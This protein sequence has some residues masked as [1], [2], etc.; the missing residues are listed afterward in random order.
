MV[1]HS[2]DIGG[3]RE[4]R[5]AL[6]RREMHA[7]AVLRSPLRPQFTLLIWLTR[8]LVGS[9]GSLVL[10]SVIAATLLGLYLAKGPIALAGL[11]PRITQ[12]LNEKVAPD[13][14]FKLGGLSVTTHGLGP[15]LAI[16]NLILENR[17]G[18]TILSAPHAEISVDLISLIYGKVVPTR[19]EI[20]G[21]EV[22]L[23]LRPDGS[24]AVSAGN[25]KQQ[26]LLVSSLTAAM[27]TPGASAPVAPELPPL[28]GAARPRSLA[29]KRIAAAL[30]LLID[31]ATRP[32]GPLAK[33]D[34]V[35]ISQGRFVIEDELNNETKLYEGLQLSLAKTGG[36][37]NLDLSAQG[38]NGPWSVSARAAGKPGAARRLDFNFKNISIDEISLVSGARNI[39][40]DFDMPVSS[41]LTVA[42]DPKNQLTDA[43]GSLHFDPGYLRFDDPNDEPRL[44]DSIDTA[45]HWDGAARQMVVDN[46]QVRTGGTDLTL[47]G[48]ITPPVREGDDWL[49]GLTNS[50]RGVYGA[51][52]PGEDQIFFDH[53]DFQ[54]RLALDNKTFHIDRLAFSGPNNG[55]AMAG[56]VDWKNGPHMSMGASLSPTPA[57]IVM[58]LWPAFMA[59]D[60]RMWFLEHVKGGIITHGT[61]RMNFD[62]AMIDHMHHQYP[63]PNPALAIDFAVSNGSLTFLK[64]VPPLDGV[65][66]SGH[67]TGRTSTFT[68]TS[69]HMQVGSV[70]VL[71]LSEGG[72]H[73]DHAEIRPTPAEFSARVTGDIRAV[74]ALLNLDALKP[75]VSL[76][77]DTTQISGQIDGQLGILLRL[78]PGADPKRDFKLS[79]DST[80][81]QFSAQKLL[82]NQDLTDATLRVS[83]NNDGLHAWGKGHCL[84]GLADIDVTRPVG[85][86]YGKAVVSMEMDDAARAKQGLAVLPGLSGPIGMRITAPLGAPGPV[87][88]QIDLDLAR[89]EIDGLGIVK[90][91]GRPGKASFELSANDDHTTTLDQLVVD[92]GGASIKGSVKIGTPDDPSQFSAHLTQVKLSPGDDARVDLSKAADTVKVVIHAVSFDG[93]PFLKTLTLTHAEDKG[94]DEAPSHAAK[95]KQAARLLAKTTTDLNIDVA[96]KAESLVG[97]NKVAMSNVDL[98]LVKNSDTLKQFALTAR[99]GRQSTIVGHLDHADSPAPQLDLTTDN[100]GGLLAFIDLYKHM[101]GG[102]LN[103]E[104][105]LGHD[106]MAGSLIVKNFVLA[107]EPALRRLVSEGVPRNTR[108]GEPA[109][110]PDAVSFRKLQVNFQRAEGRLDISDGVIYGSQIGVTANG[111]LDFAASRV[112]LQGTFV[113]AYDVNNFFTKIP[114]FGLLAGGSNE[115]LFAI[116]YH[117]VGSP[118]QPTLN[119]NPFSIAPGILRKIFGSI[120]LTNPDSESEA[121]PPPGA[122]GRQ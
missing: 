70:G 69:G 58:R 93:R 46:A 96:M 39:G 75:F 88:A 112:D 9:R 105:R 104:M 45:F 51:E 116:N 65:E 86:P 118:R 15:T 61:L 98:H 59:A 100:A 57:K 87:K 23:A 10:I 35:A 19:L 5:D 16:D 109:F 94:A 117:I 63:P 119:I 99:M 101:K 22:R 120:D 8:R 114:F 95:G 60:I 6:V 74:G 113:P 97:F 24:L 37:T 13:Y 67:I 111:W 7:P 33:I 28:A 72:F 1:D 108:T 30:R 47:H 14:A 27:A 11:G 12:A 91:A 92:A 41:H 106:A 43:S 71:T 79:V 20:F 80:T 122:D 31:I 121:P 73:I 21:V 2:D 26:S 53:I 90:P 85:A 25:G 48:A 89:A 76:P 29:M 103:V 40:A 3:V 54:G 52:R 18:A 83:V 84:G 42:I 32:T 66:G 17:E 77:V 36:G 38:P 110:D 107:D 56:A 78:G 4:T 82:G 55:F 50:K 115:G 34:R 49:I 44:I 102:V 64:G 62:A 68:A 81:T